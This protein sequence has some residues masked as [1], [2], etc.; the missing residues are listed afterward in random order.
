[1]AT[2][3][4]HMEHLAVGLLTYAEL[5]KKDG[6]EEEADFFAALYSS[7]VRVTTGIKPSSGT[8]EQY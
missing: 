7:L 1:M 5:L 2:V 6:M 3:A 8:I 4:S